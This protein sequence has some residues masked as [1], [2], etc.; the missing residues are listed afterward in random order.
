MRH[1][2][3]MS[4]RSRRVAF[5]FGLSVSVFFLLAVSFHPG[6]AASWTAFDNIG[7][8]VTPFVAAISCFAIARRSA[9]RESA[10]WN[11]IALGAASW[12]LG[13]LLWTYFD[14]G[15]GQQPVSPS[16]CDIGFLLSPVLTIAGLLLFVETPA[17]QLSRLRGILEAVLIAGGLLVAAWALLLEPVVSTS[18]APLREELVTIAYPVLDAVS[19]AA[20]IFTATRRRRNI[21]GRLTVLGSGIACLAVADSSFWYLTTVKNVDGANP[22]H[23]GWFIGFLVV[24]WSV[25]DKNRPA[26]AWQ[27]AAAVTRRFRRLRPPPAVRSWIALALPEL[28]ALLG[29][30]IASL[31]DVIAAPKPNVAYLYI[32]TA[33]GC[34]ALLHGLAVLMENHALTTNLEARILDRTAELGRRERHFN[35]LVEHSSDA[36][37]VLTPELVIYS[38]T[39]SVR[40]VLGVDRA[41]LVTRRLD[42]LDSSFAGLA[43]S[44]TA[45][46]ATTDHSRQVT[47]EMGSPDAGSR[48]LD[49]H[50]TNLVADADVRGYVVNTRDV[51]ERVQLERE[52]RH[53]AFHD[54]LSGLP[55]RALFYDRGEHALARARRTGDGVAVIAIDL[56]GFK[57]VN[58]SLGHHAGDAL[59]RSVGEKLQAATRVGDTL[60]RLGGDEFAVLVED[61]KDRTQV[62]GIAERL[63]VCVGEQT[64][65]ADYA[66][67]ASIGVAICYDDHSSIE[68]LLRDADIAMYVA[69]S[70]GKNAVQ[71]FEAWMHDRASERFRL[72]SE[73]PGALDRGEFVLYYQPCWT[74]K[75][76][77]LEGFE[78]LL[79]WN[80]PVL[81]LIPPD[82]FIPLAEESGII[83][84][85]GVW[86]LQE[87][88]RQL[89]AWSRA[90]P[91]CSDLTMAINVSARQIRDAQLVDHVRVAIVGAQ[92]DARRIV[93]EVTESVL[94]HDPRE[95]AD[96][97][98]QLKAA[99]VRIAIDDFGTGY[100]SLSYLQEL[101]IDILKIDKAFVSKASGNETDDQRMLSAIVTLAQNLGLKTVAEGVETTRQAALLTEFGCDLAQGFLWARPLPPLDA[102]SLLL[103][104]STVPACEVA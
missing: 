24:A 50:I 12:G 18:T 89:A 14:V 43:G 23:A 51:T 5:W 104:T 56:D 87:A 58:D 61:L 7:Q 8:T 77:A 71:L 70:N 25:T 34:V 81:G 36:T 22:S 20:L 15:L 78:A 54:Q 37:L 11:L 69:K 85:I 73:L 21:H 76:G 100:S 29:V 27:P 80:H 88:T 10:A 92:V 32:L 75:T 33:V 68:E 48:I 35:A 30:I 97:L 64:S 91:T 26:G 6:G 41:D 39:E 65:A 72:Q 57:H 52:I 67:T 47:W 1:A 28:V 60:A 90:I 102:L 79:R 103:A 49:S 40:S 3:S 99:G 38:A 63:R 96:K 13:Q 19:L 17:A 44:F 101:P 74:L 98:R 16:I 2:A 45:F 83:V 95:V 31:Y 84:A 46:A 82:H 94:V 42:E 66:V 86:V 9:R 93:L 53:Q 4:P 59:L 62:A 55:N